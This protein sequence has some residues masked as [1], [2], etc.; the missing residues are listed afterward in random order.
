MNNEEYEK[1]DKTDMLLEKN[2]KYQSVI[3]WVDLKDLEQHVRVPHSPIP[4][5]VDE[6]DVGWIDVLGKMTFM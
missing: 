1:M 3:V 6:N 4:L 2:K 5:V